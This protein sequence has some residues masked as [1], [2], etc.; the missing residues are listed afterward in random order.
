M[1]EVKIIR[2]ENVKPTILR[3]KDK[4]D[5]LNEWDK[6]VEN[7]VGGFKYQLRDAEA[8]RIMS[9]YTPMNKGW[10]NLL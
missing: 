4:S 10:E 7:A 5:A 9:E 8:G 2:G 6:V 3:Y 1:Y